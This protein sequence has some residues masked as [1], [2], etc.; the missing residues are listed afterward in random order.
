MGFCVGGVVYLLVI[1]DFVFMVDQSSYMFI[2]GLQ[3]IKI[4]IYEEVIK[5]EL[6][7]VMIYVVKSGVVYLVVVDEKE[8]LV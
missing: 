5:E 1:I 7:G 6:G 3:V 4:V 8:C 2:I